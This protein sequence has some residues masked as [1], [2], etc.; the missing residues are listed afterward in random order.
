MYLL[1][2]IFTFILISECHAKEFTIKLTKSEKESSVVRLHIFTSERINKTITIKY[3]SIQAYQFESIC[4]A[5]TKPLL[6]F[7]MH[8]FAETWNM[9]YRWNWV[10]PMIAE[11]LKTPEASKLCIIAVDWKVKHE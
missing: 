1:V 7:I 6:K 5:R 3:K 9:T 8:G 11:M 10:R 2:W 4:P